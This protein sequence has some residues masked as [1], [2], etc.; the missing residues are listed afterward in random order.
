[1]HKEPKMKRFLPRLSAAAAL[2]ATSTAT[3]AHD[4]H[5]LAPSHWHPTDTAGFAVVA[6]LAGMAIWLSR[7]R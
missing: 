5:G 3:L 2:L 7:E 6:L 1:M 4:G